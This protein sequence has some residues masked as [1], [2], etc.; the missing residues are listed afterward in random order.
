MK[1]TLALAALVL[2]AWLSQ[3]DEAFH[4]PDPGTVMTFS[5]GGSLTFTTQEGLTCRARTNKGSLVS[6]FLGLAVAVS[7]SDLEKNHGERLFPWRVGNQIDFMTSGTTA[8]ATGDLVTTIK[9]VYFDN[10]IKVVG[11]ERLVT[12]AGSFD[13]FVVEWHRQV[14]GRWSGTWL[15]TVWF[16]PELGYTIKSKHETRQGYGPDTSYEIASIALPK[17]STAPAARAT[18]APQ[19]PTRSAALPPAPMPTNAAAID[20]IKLEQGNGTFLVPVQV[21]G[22]LTLNF[23]LDS[24]AADVAIP[25]DVVQ[26]LT[27]AG[28]ISNS[29]FIGTKTY[30]LADG[31]KLPSEAFIVHELRVGDHVIRNVT[32]SV[33]PIQ[34]KLLLGQS[35]LSKLPA[36]TIDNKQHALIITG[37]PAG[38]GGSAG[39]E[40]VAMAP[41][42]SVAVPPKAAPAPQPAK[43]AQPPA[44]VASVNSSPATPPVVAASAHAV[45][46]G[47]TGETGFRC[48]HAG[49]FV[50]YSNGATLKFA[51]ESGFRCAYVDQNYRDAEKFAGFADDAKFLDAGLDKLW[52]LTTGKQ[53]AISVSISGAYLT[54]RFTVLRT[55]TVVTPA[56]TFDVFVI[57][58]EE[59][60]TGSQWAKRLFWYAPETGLIVKSTFSLLK[61]ADTAIRGGN[62]AASLVPGDYQAVRIEGSSGKSPQ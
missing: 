46:A 6:Q 61:T 3:A 26:I 57:E 14:K 15:T 5:D 21:N 37:D 53:Q 50:Q 56:G 59:T 18:P 62:A 36:W 28:T 43:V 17:G 34:G 47:T 44:P 10:T 19:P 48:P 1:L 33:T 29:D 9:D 49:T 30:V 7:D 32:A 54:H 60:G 45:G 24:G 51:G 20:T 42:A 27:R 58:Q 35:F 40:P 22:R 25:A 52:P 39:V 11:Q 12:A 23:V 2:L 31:S 55:E 41:Q 4:C 38:S 13:T 8:N 16:A